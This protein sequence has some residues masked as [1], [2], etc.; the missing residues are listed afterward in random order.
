MLPQASTTTDAPPPPVVNT[1]LLPAA[2]LPPPPAVDPLQALLA[3]TRQGDIAVVDSLLNQLRLAATVAVRFPNDSDA[4][5]LLHWAALEGGP[6]MVQYLCASKQAKPD[7][8]NS[9]GET[10]LHWACIKGNVKVVHLLADMFAADLF[11]ADAKGYSCMHFAAQNGQTLVL[12]M[13]HRRG[14][15][16]NVRDNDGRTPLH[17]AAY[18]NHAFAARWLLSHGG[19][20][21]ALDWENCMPIHWASLRGHADMVRMLVEVAGCGPALFVQEKTGGTPLSLAQDKIVRFTSNTS[22]STDPAVQAMVLQLK[23]VVEYCQYRMP[24]ETELAARQGR[25]TLWQQ[26]QHKMPHFSW[27]LW[28]VMAPPGLWQ[29]YVTVF[30]P[31]S[32]LAWTH[33]VFGLCYLATWYFWARLQVSDPGDFVV[34]RVGMTLVCILTNLARARTVPPR[35]SSTRRGRSGKKLRV[36][37]QPL[38]SVGG[39]PV[40]RFH[41]RAKRV[42]HLNHR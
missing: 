16:V 21:D 5:P 27:F 9:R 17:W 10:A 25:P 23:R 26:A 4:H 30:A 41:Q 11:A 35:P 14:Q 37:T 20:P 34:V 1:S 39:V 31:T 22:T 2:I 24:I 36:A 38:A 19:D 32:H 29:Y 18:K 7:A 42:R 8:R 40:H 6:A 28:P 12:A 15:A 33:L 3:A 13:L